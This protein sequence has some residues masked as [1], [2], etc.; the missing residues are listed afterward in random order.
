MKDKVGKHL[1]CRL[2]EPN[3]EN[4]DRLI[5]LTG[6]RRH[7]P[8]SNFPARA[9]GRSIRRHS[10]NGN[11]SGGR[12]ARIS[13]NY[14]PWRVLAATGSILLL[15]R[16]CGRSKHYKQH[17]RQCN[18]SSHQLHLRGLRVFACGH[19]SSETACILPKSQHIPS[20]R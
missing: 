16:R 9:D 11:P 19:S 20:R 3:Q 18:S 1:S 5:L 4:G 13:G 14:Q 7:C 6:N 15:R 2:C 10:M 12:L 17:S 8:I